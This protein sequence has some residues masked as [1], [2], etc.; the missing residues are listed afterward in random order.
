MKAADGDT[1]Y[2]RRDNEARPDDSFM[3]DT[4]TG[5]TLLATQTGQKWN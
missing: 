3:K 4:A 1:I 5:R 2:F